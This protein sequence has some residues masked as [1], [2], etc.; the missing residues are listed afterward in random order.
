ML[1]SWFSPTDTV[2][3]A[4]LVPQMTAGALIIWLAWVAVFDRRPA[5]RRNA[6]KVLRLILRNGKRQERS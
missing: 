6:L 2:T 5:R 4:V 3:L 1:G